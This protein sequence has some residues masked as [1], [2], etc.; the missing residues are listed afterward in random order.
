LT[1]KTVGNS[2]EFRAKVLV[3]DKHNAYR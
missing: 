3:P 2:N 1:A